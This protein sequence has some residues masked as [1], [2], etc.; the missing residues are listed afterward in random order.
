MTKSRWNV[1]V[2]TPAGERSGVLELTTDGKQLTGFMSDGERHVPIADG[3][4]DGESLSWTARIS[5]PMSLSLKFTASIEGD[6]ISGAA[7]HF[8]GKASF[9]GKRA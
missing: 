4:V 6:R 7:K 8:L 1:V 5:K 9:S 2:K 3:R